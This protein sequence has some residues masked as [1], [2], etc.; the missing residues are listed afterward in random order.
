MEDANPSFYEDAGFPLPIYADYLEDYLGIT[1]VKQLSIL[2]RA[3]VQQETDMPPH[4][5]DHFLRRTE[6][7]VHITEELAE[8][9]T[10]REKN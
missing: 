9:R 7:F 5:L 3:L 4:I 8:G 1:D 6:E 10:V 2:P